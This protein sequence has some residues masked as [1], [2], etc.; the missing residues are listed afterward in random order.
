MGG[1]TPT[2]YLIVAC[3]SG[4]TYDIITFEPLGLQQSFSTQ[5]NPLNE[6]RDWKKVLIPQLNQW[7]RKFQNILQTRKIQNFWFRSF[8]L[9]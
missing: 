8:N 3:K 4:K 6:S 5:N 1:Q 9:K 2:D 7:A